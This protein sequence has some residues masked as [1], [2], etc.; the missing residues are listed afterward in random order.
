MSSFDLFLTI[1]IPSILS[2]PF[3]WILFMWA[4][5]EAKNDVKW[6]RYMNAWDRWDANGR[7]GKMPVSKDFGYKG[8]DD[9]E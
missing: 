1:A 8:I 2:A 6:E 3:I 7:K 5:P 9:K 4:I